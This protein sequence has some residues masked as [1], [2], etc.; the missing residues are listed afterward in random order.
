[1]RKTKRRFF[2]LFFF[3]WEFSG[4]FQFLY[5]FSVLVRS[6]GAKGTARQ[7]ANSNVQ[8]SKERKERNTRFLPSRRKKK[9]IGRPLLVRSCISGKK[10]AC[11]CRRWSRQFTRQ[12][13][14]KT[15]ERLRVN[16]S[17]TISFRN[18][19]WWYKYSVS[20]FF[21]LFQGLCCF[22]SSFMCAV[23]HICGCL[24]RTAKT[25]SFRVEK[26]KQRIYIYIRERSENTRIRRVRRLSFFSFI[27]F[28]EWV[29]IACARVYV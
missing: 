19:D 28:E 17:L 15:K 20:L 22:S 13:R 16:V 29:L 9:G 5:R 25:M 14:K 24:K 8:E 1:M 27:L 18:Y 10:M 7:P 11:T 6:G 3:S 21:L 23:L 4:A 12:K 2:P 26:K